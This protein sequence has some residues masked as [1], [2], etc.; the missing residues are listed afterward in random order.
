M[1]C[2]ILIS[3]ILTINSQQLSTYQNKDTNVRFF[4]A[5]ILEIYVDTFHC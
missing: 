5:A 4:I 3:E 2:A 1:I